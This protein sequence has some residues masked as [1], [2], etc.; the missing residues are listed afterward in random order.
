MAIV[1]SLLMRLESRNKTINPNNPVLLFG[2][3]ALFFYLAHFAGR[4]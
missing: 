1:L 3:T 4:Y 2:Q